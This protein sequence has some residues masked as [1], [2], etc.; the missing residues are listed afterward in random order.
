MA[1]RQTTGFVENLLQLTG[2]DW[3]VSDV[4]TLSRRQKTLVVNIPHRASKGPQHLLI[5]STGFKVEGEGEWT[6]RK[7]G[8]PKRRVWPKIHLG[9]V[10][11]TPKVRSVE[12]K[13]INPRPRT[14]SKSPVCGALAKVAQIY[15]M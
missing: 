7:Y 4:S 9:I 5:D 8:G 15:S 12:V 2:L 3:D 6:A 10:E 13:E 14:I 11:E 1:L